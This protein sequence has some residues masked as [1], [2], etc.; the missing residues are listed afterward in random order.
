MGDIRFSPAV[1]SRVETALDR[2]AIVLQDLSN[3]VKVLHQERAKLVALH[4]L[5]LSGKSPVEAVKWTD[6]M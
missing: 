2:A 5:V 6:R 4:A 1:E 3:L